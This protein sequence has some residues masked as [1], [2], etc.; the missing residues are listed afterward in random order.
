MVGIRILGLLGNHLFQIA[1]LYNLKKK[2]GYKT[3]IEYG[4]GRMNKPRVEKYFD[5]AGYNFWTNK[6]LQFWY[7]KIVK[8]KYIDLNSELSPEENIAHITE[9]CI[10]NGFVQ[11]EQYFSDLNESIKDIFKIKKKYIN[12][13][14]LKY[15][16]YFNLDKKSIVVHL[17]RGDYN[18]TGWVLPLSYYQSAF[19]CI[20]DI[21]KYNIIFVSDDIEFVKEKFTQFSAAVFICDSEIIDFQIIKNADI[22]IIANSSFSWWAA[23]LN[24]KTDKVIYAPKNWLGFK[25]NKEH[26][27]GIMSVNWNWLEVN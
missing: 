6:L 12:E 18:E 15:G 2:F 5:I 21:S 7:T 26:P 27:V 22:A 8:L 1:F 13:F 11:S 17:R 10:Y 4:N 25:E 3:F 19:E 14:Q 9:N 20:N 23:Y 24:E 16:K